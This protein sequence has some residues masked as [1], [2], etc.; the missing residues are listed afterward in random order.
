LRHVLVC[1]CLCVSAHAGILVVRSEQG[2]QL[3]S[4]VSI[5][6]DG[7][8]KVLSLGGQPTIGAAIS[9]LATARL[10]GT[11]LKDAD[12]GVLL[13]YEAGKAD[14]LLPQDLPK[15]AT[16][17]PAEV[18]KTAKIVYKPS[19]SDKAGTSI[20][21]SSFVAFLPA[22]V[23]D[24]AALCKDTQALQLIAGKGKSF[25]A[26]VELMSA[27][28]KA[29][30][31]DPALASLEKYVEDAMRRR[32]E[33]FENGTGGVEALT[34]GLQFGEL[35]Q[36]VYPNSE[37]Q[38]KLRQLLAGRKAWLDRKIAVQKALAAAAQ[39]DAFILGDRDLERYR[40]A[41]PE[42]VKDRAQAL[43]GSLDL[44]VKTATELQSEGDYGAAYREFRL[45]NLR[46][47]TDSALREQAMQSWTEY[48]RRHATDSQAQRSKLAAGPQS[49]VE[50]SLFFAEQNKLARKLDDALKNVRDAE[51][52]LSSS[53]PAG[54]VSNAALKVWYAK[55]D[56][57]G[58]QDRIAEALA[59]LDAYDLYAVDEERAQADKL[60]NQLLFNLGTS[61]KNLKA[62][63][64]TAWAEGSFSAAQQLAD[65]GLKMDADDADLLYYAG[66]TALVKRDPK[67]GRDYLTRYLG[68]SSTLDADAER[69]AMAVRW[70]SSIAAP[71]G[72]ARQGGANWLSGEK[73][74]KGVFYC[75]LS[76]A[77]QPHID[78]I[79]A[80]GKFHATFDW[81]GERLK[82]IAP[83]FENADRPTAEKRI[84]FRYE[85]RVPQVVW[86]SDSAEARP[87]APADPDAAYKN[88]PVLLPNN[89]LVDLAAIRRMAGKNLALTVAGNPFFNPFVWESLHYFRLTYDDGGRVSRAQELSG[90]TGAPGAQVLEF[91][92]NG[93]Q[94]T[95]IRGYVGNTKNYERTMQYQDGLLVGE[96]IQGRGKPSRIKY[97][98]AA[99]RLVS[100]E[101]TADATL[102]NRGRKVTFQTNSPSTIVK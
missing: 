64:Q 62:R 91:E 83:S 49:A 23:E 73:L 12:S 19:A 60:R 65:Q 77:F 17:D 14:Y 7:K 76:L 63:L 86:A 66:S 82:S 1:A 38:L 88:A 15:N 72:E 10:E 31:A 35:S 13:Q 87:A 48:S 89:P 43:Q 18:W 70:L 92:W 42:I 85:D 97:S 81:D 11:L 20:S 8:D 61:L 98:Y 21:I 40:E 29:Y 39:W 100:A 56:I 34:Q 94:L 26:Q 30:P 25:Q 37:G 67:L 36:S 53:Q 68:V 4:A 5:A 58:A 59:A 93:M 55:A 46:K 96:E 69:R 16:V 80:S 52:V 32:L 6:I 24:L 74:P 78:R 54:T 2:L 75:P 45:A 41:F 90:P 27:A 95:A 50:R 71:P 99:N 9:K 102:D 44:H 84:S 57:L 79:D 47:P 28:V 101:A 3:N 22:G 51:A 33:A